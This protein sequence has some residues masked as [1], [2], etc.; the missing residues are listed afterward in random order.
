MEPS[1]QRGKKDMK[2][3]GKIAFSVFKDL[4]RVSFVMLM[5]SI[6][7]CGQGEVDSVL[8]PIST[9]VRLCPTRRVPILQ[10]ATTSSRG[11]LCFCLIGSTLEVPSHPL[12][13]WTELET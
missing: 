4:S 3:K 2:E 5:R 10:K 8:T 11:P 7:R 6:P 1:G 9:G 12:Q 13:W